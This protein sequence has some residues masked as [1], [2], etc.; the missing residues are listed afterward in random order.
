MAEPASHTP[1]SPTDEALLLRQLALVDRVLGLEAEV[2]RLSILAPD[3]S[4][5]RGHDFVERELQTVYGSTTW[6]VGR[7]VLAPARAVR[8]LLRR[9]K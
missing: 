2:A 4:G 5:P 6:R 8:A 9:A 7:A 1:V 3:S